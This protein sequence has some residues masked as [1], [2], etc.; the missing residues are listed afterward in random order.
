[1][2]LLDYLA[3]AIVGAMLTLIVLGATGCATVER[4]TNNYGQDYNVETVQWARA[5]QAGWLT[6]MIMTLV[7]LSMQV[8]R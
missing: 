6:T 5:K 1:M 8:D 3:A 2:K 4:K 7:V